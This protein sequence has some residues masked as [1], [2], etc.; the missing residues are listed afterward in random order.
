MCSTLDP[1]RW[2]VDCQCR[3]LHVETSWKDNGTKVKVLLLTV[4][5]AVRDLEV[6]PWPQSQ[7][8]NNGVGK[9]GTTTF[10]PCSLT[11]LC[12][13]CFAGLFTHWA[14][15]GELGWGSWVVLLEEVCKERGLIRFPLFRCFFF[16]L[17][18]SLVWLHVLVH[19][20]CFTGLFYLS[21]PSPPS[22]SPIHQFPT[23]HWFHC[24]RL[25]LQDY[26]LQF[27]HPSPVL[28]YFNWLFSHL[29]QVT[30]KVK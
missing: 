1:L 28:W 30:W 13:C 4:Y 18:V 16:L 29:S 9:W 23:H 15:E 22:T 24:F 3:Y 10:S 2:S 14:E 7:W 17:S 5:C 20:C 11:H 6:V 12:Y 26:H 27:N 19:Y 21:F 8:K 25:P